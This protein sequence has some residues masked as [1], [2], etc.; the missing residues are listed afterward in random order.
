MHS[1][2]GE[3]GR[4][5]ALKRAAE[6]TKNIFGED[7]SEYKKTLEQI[8]E[9]RVVIKRWQNKVNSG[10]E[11]PFAPDYSGTL[12]SQIQA[13]AEYEKDVIDEKSSYWWEQ[14]AKKTDTL[15]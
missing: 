13:K 14:D 7:S 9:Q 11:K 10:E 2:K 5:K 6:K 8:K 1:L 12:Q 4:L 3:K 15:G